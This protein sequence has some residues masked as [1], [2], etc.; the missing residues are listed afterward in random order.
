MFW[1][2]VLSL[3]TS[4]FVIGLSVYNDGLLTRDQTLLLQRRLN[5]LN[6]ELTRE[7][8]TGLYSLDQC[9]ISPLPG[10]TPNEETSPKKE[11]ALSP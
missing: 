11:E 10:D 7:S 3:V 9:T 1:Y 8:G 4:I 6:C 2:A 5:A